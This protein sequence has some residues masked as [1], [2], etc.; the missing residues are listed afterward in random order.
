MVLSDFLLPKS[1]AGSLP[2]SV[3][4]KASRAQ[5]NAVSIYRSRVCFSYLQT[6]MTPGNKHF[7][8][9]FIGILF[10]W[11]WKEWRESEKTSL[12]GSKL[13][14]SVPLARV[15]QAETQWHLLGQWELPLGWLTAPLFHRWG[16][17]THLVAG[18]SGAPSSLKPLPTSHAVF[19]CLCPCL[20]LSHWSAR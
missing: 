19:P 3:V 15:L 2:K 10:S 18:S 12:E 4:I 5:P 8:N 16:K 1:E 9:M 6:Q 11:S 17:A 20:C 14:L 13:L 7:G